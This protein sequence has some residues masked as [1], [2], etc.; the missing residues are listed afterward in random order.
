MLINK[1]SICYV[2]KGLK[3]FLR[4]HCGFDLRKLAK[5]AVCHHSAGFPDPPLAQPH[6][7]WTEVGAI[8][9]RLLPARFRSPSPCALAPLAAS[10]AVPSWSSHLNQ[11]PCLVECKSDQQEMKNHL[12]SGHSHEQQS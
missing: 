5:E 12:N 3:P 8:Y 1:H 2:N 10:P 11:A 7:C 9:H 6:P 4:K